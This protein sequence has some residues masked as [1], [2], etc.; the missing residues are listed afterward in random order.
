MYLDRPSVSWPTRLRGSARTLAAV[1]FTALLAAALMARWSDVSAT[2]LGTFS[3]VDRAP[4]VGVPVTLE[5]SVVGAGEG[6]IALI[7]QGSQSPVA[8]AVS[9]DASVMRGGEAVALEDLRVGDN[10]RMTIDGLTGTALRMHAAPAASSAF[11]PRVPGA[12]AFLAALGFIAGATA[13]AILNIERIPAILP[14]RAP[15]PRL[16]PAEAAR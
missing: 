6:K 13:L 16:A 7:E 1:V 14:H 5:G 2:G 8:F 12:V 10:V 9:G 15:A 4:V 11:V 3:P